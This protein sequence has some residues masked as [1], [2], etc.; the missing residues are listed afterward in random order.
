MTAPLVIDYYTDVLCVWAWIAQRRIEELQDEWGGKVDLRCHYMDVFGDTASKMAEQWQ[1]RG[2]YEG[3][4]Q[5]VVDSA[6]P[7][8][9]APVNE[10]IWRDVRPL[11][12]GNSHLVLKA[13]QLAASAAV[14]ADLAL[15]LRRSFFVDAMDIGR[16]D[17]LLSLAAQSGLDVEKIQLYLENGQAMAALQ[18]DYHMAQKMGLK[19][20][21]SWV[22]NGGRQVLFGNVGYRILSAN[23]KEILAHPANDVSWC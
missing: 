17:V 16:I 18:R 22:M 21:P 14:S 2:G 8:D 1:S 9:N 3:F 7:F 19:G 12:S 6:K 4:G 15:L 5:H 23:V 10:G 20:S 13:A 11:T